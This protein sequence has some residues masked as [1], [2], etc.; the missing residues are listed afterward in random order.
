MAKAAEGLRP[1]RTAPKDINLYDRMRV[2]LLGIQ[3]N[4]HHS[5]WRVGKALVLGSRLAL[6]SLMRYLRR[7]PLAS[8]PTKK[9]VGELIDLEKRTM[10]EG[11][12]LLK[13]AEAA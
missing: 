10:Q 3:I 4:P 1:F 5:E 9:L 2:D 8:H 13:I 12:R 6:L 7:Y 11:L